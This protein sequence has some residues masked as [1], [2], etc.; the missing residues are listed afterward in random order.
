M[1]WQRII[2]RG[3]TPLTVGPVIAGGY[4]MARTG[5]AGWQS[6]AI[7]AVAVALTLRTRLNPLWIVIAGGAFGG[8]GLL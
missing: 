2:R 6:A 8:L 3:V 4:V 7:S 5:N 1:P